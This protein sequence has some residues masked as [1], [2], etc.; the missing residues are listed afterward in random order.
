MGRRMK[1]LL[2]GLALILILGISLLAKSILSFPSYIRIVPEQEHLFKVSR[3]LTMAPVDEGAGEFLSVLQDGLSI[4]A[5]KLGPIRLQLSLLGL[6]P[7][8][9]VV[10]DVVSETHVVPG[11]QAIGVL[12]SSGGLIVSQTVP[13]IDVNGVERYPAQ[14]A[15]IRYGDIV[16]K[17]NGIEVND[18]HQVGALVNRFAQGNQGIWLEVQR[19]RQTLRVP[20]QPVRVNPRT[21]RPGVSSEYLIGILLEEPTAGVGTVTFADP[22]SGKFAALGHKITDRYSRTLPVEDGRI[23]RAYIDGIQVGTRGQPGEKIGRFTGPK[24]EIGVVHKNTEFGIYGVLTQPNAVSGRT[25]PVALASEVTTGP[26]QIRTVLSGHKVETFDVEIIKV[27]QQSRP[28]SKGLVVKIV[29][30]RLLQQAGGIVQGMSG[31][32][33]L[34]RGKLVGAITHVFVN[35]PTKGFGILAEW[36]IYEAGVAGTN[37]K[38][39]TWNHPGVT[40]RVAAAGGATL[41][42]RSVGKEGKII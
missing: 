10:V 38:G 35:D 19:G 41:Q 42:W 34:Q 17:I 11:G 29:D 6:V 37:V 4:K 33:I 15:G 21:P 13:V 9:E 32:P 14:A 7:L 2:I 27:V 8:R 31:S 22:A 16:R 39:H 18:P 1:G 40:P 26:A 30:P 23:V 36:M 20:V 3:W 12:L 28:E 5:S 25:V 24:D